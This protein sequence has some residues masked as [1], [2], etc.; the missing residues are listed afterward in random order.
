MSTPAATY[1]PKEIV[2]SG[3]GVK[4]LAFI[5]ALT[6]ADTSRLQSAIGTS[7][8]AFL[9][10]L[11]ASG[12]TPAELRSIFLEL[13]WY[14]LFQS[15]ILSTLTNLTQTFAVN[16]GSKVRH[17]LHH[18]L[19]NKLG[20]ENPSFEELPVDLCVVATN[21]NT[22]EAEEFSKRR[23][24]K[25]SVVEAVF[26]SMCLPLLFPP[27]TIGGETYVDGSL[28]NN[29]PVNLRRLP[30]ADGLYLRMGHG[31][32]CPAPTR[33]FD[34]YMSRVVGCMLST[35]QELTEYPDA[36]QRRVKVVYCPF[37]TVHFKL[38]AKQKEAILAA[39]LE[40]LYMCSRT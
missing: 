21:L 18:L 15:N 8:G 40:S 6:L 16:G 3:G 14:T 12:Y 35:P 19:Y 33:S 20:K 13:D 7:M 9:A 24:P 30:C 36:V 31:K 28:K 17:L 26:A 27:Q 32:H 38:S 22:N 10:C 37:S 39:G 2:L 29:F 25:Q 1:C 34:S 4:A 5:G 11:L 23:T